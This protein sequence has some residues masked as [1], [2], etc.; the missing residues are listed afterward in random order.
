MWSCKKAQQHKRDSQSCKIPEYLSCKNT[1]GE[2]IAKVFDDKTQV[3]PK[4]ICVLRV[5]KQDPDFGRRPKFR[6]GER[7]SQ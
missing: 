6:L 3:R 2:Q 4:G 5:V 1:T 7:G